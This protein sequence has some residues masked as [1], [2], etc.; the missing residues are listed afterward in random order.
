MRRGTRS[1][2]QAPPPEVLSK[3]LDLLVSPATSIAAIYF[4]DRFVARK[5]NGGGN[6]TKEIAQHLDLAL[7]RHFDWLRRDLETKISKEHED[8]RKEWTNSLQRFLLDLE[9]FVLSEDPPV[10]KRRR[11]GEL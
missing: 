7:T 1:P 8:T 5:R 3:I 6:T 10:G 4:Y 2:V 11:K 9:V